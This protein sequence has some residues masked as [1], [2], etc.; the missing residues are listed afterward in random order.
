[1]L[2]AI[3]RDDVVMATKLGEVLTSSFEVLSEAMSFL[4][5]PRGISEWCHIHFHISDFGAARRGVNRTDGSVY[6]RR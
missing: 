6:T 1:V 4:S 2:Y 3:A 5:E